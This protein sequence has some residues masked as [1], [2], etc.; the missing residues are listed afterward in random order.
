MREGVRGWLK[1]GISVGRDIYRERNGDLRG[2]NFQALTKNTLTNNL[3]QG[4]LPIV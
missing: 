1:G 2:F 3:M 4:K